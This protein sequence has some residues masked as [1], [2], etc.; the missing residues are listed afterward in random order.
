MCDLGDTMDPRDVI[1]TRLAQLECGVNDPDYTSDGNRLDADDII[2][3]LAD[4]GWQ[5]VPTDMVVNARGFLDHLAEMER[6]DDP[7]ERDVFADV[8]TIYRNAL[9]ASLAALDGADPLDVFRGE[10]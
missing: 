8:A 5:I 3:T 2:R 9:A 7:R 1:A 10:P 6:C 4:C